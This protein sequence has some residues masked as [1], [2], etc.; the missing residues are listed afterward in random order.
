MRLR[1]VDYDELCT[2]LHTHIAKYVSQNSPSRHYIIR[3]N[4]DDTFEITTYQDSLKLGTGNGTYHLIQTSEGDTPSCYINIQYKT[5]VNSPHKTSP[6][7]P[8]NAFYPKLKDYT[9]GP[10]YT[11]ES[12]EH[13]ESPW[14][15]LLYPHLT[16]L[17]TFKILNMYPK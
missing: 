7:N 12:T 1:L 11:W 9:I 17:G 3:Y 16:R 10:F 8:D 2:I 6:M 5:I 14:I 13:Q 15:P 4:D